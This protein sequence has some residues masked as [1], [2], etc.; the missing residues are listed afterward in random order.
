M[1]L[2][3]L[4]AD[5][6]FRVWVTIAYL[7]MSLHFTSK[8]I[9][10]YKEMFPIKLC[11]KII[12]QPHK[13]WKH[14]VFLCTHDNSFLRFISQHWN[15]ESLKPSI[16]CMG[17]RCANQEAKWLQPITSVASTSLET[18]GVRFACTAS[19]RWPPLHLSEWNC[20]S[21]NNFIL[22]ISNRLR[23]YCS[24]LLPVHTWS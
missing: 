7:T 18:R 6:K 13:V 12:L 8:K 1:H 11:I 14:F 15:F 21:N 22:P 23:A 16:S 24:A 17:G 10:L 20:L 2:D 9:S 5:H 19:T 3:G 4:N